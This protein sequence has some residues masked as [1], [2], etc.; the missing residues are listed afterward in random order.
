MS[1]N[2]NTLT[3]ADM[4]SSVYE[5]VGLSRVESADLVD[6]VFDLMA[7]GLVD[8]GVLKLSSFGTFQVRKEKARVG[9]N[10]KTGVEVTITPRS[11]VTYKA[12]HILKE[13][14]NTD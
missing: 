2:I 6:D 13:K 1:D 14:M 9:R 8:S 10:P 7:D 5:E 4:A 3:R 12:S 11:V